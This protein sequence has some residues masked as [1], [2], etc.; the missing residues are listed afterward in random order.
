MIKQSRNENQS[1]KHVNLKKFRRTHIP[2]VQGISNQ[3]PK[4]IFLHYQSRLWT[5][6]EEPT[7]LQNNNEGRS[8]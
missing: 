3:S 8:C 4:L 5:E 7:R 1:H 6:E 2:E